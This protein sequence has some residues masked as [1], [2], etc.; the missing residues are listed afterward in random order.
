MTGLAMRQSVRISLIAGL[1]LLGLAPGRAN[2]DVCVTIDETRD[3]FS[4]QDRAAALLLLTR[5]FELAGEHVVPPGCPTAYVVS[6]VQLGT[7]VTITLSGPA[8]QRDATAIGMNDVPVVY[9]QMVRSLLRGQP[10]DAPGVVDRTN[11]STVQAT[12]HR[13]YSDSVAYTRLGYGGI[14]GDRTYGGPA[15]GIFGYRKEL[16]AFAIDV[17]FLNFQYESYDRSYGYGPAGSS[18]MS[19]AWLKLEALRFITPLAD[20][21]PYIGG[22]LSWSGVNLDNADT[23]W[24]G[25]G[26]QGELTAG[27]E[28]ARASTIRVF[29]QADAGLPM[30]KLRSE[31]YSYSTSYPYVSLTT[32]GHR[33][34]PSLSLSLGLGWQ[35]GGGK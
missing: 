19:G 4:P 24:S 26:L 29:I 25:S 33:Y 21:S 10:M 23:S 28:L 15:V 27:Y 5:Q 14:F 6:H 17:S 11:V 12:R 20:R 7:M 30:Y 3:T 18:G 8:G 16:D 13:I 32:V 22:G 34:A 35:R 1:L 31:K 9:S 2:A